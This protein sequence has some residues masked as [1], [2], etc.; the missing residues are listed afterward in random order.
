MPMR[1]R[2]LAGF[3]KAATICAADP[4]W[5]R[6]QPSQRSRSSH[7]D[8]DDLCDTEHPTW[9]HRPI[10]QWRHESAA[11]LPNLPLHR[12]R[13]A[14]VRGRSGA[15][16]CVPSV[17]ARVGLRPVDIAASG[18]AGASVTLSSQRP[19]IAQPPRAASV[20]CY[21]PSALPPRRT[22]RNRPGRDGGACGDPLRQMRNRHGGTVGVVPRRQ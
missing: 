16:V 3:S 8:S 12:C 21:R 9:S 15:V 5:C 18:V 10:M 13:G 11:K 20:S 2:P 4:E 6:T 17:R 14:R 7:S 1:R 19:A 22:P